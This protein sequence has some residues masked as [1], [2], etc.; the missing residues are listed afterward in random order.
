MAE[1]AYPFPG[2]NSYLEHPVLWEPVH[3]RLIIEIADQLQPRLDP[4]YIASVEERV[5][6]EGPR[7][8]SRGKTQPRSQGNAAVIVKIE[9]LEVRQRRI[10]ILDSYD[11]MKLVA[12]IE[13]V[14][15]SN[16]R[17]GPGR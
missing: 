5:Y 8:R 7:D 16:K 6:V 13:L 3:T 15:P 4:R 2:M 12:V 1:A 11:E 14:S 9:A 17:S 10:E